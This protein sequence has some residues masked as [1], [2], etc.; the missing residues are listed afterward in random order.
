ME[1]DIGE[2]LRDGIDRVTE[3]NGLLLVGAFVLAGIASTVV[4]QTLTAHVVDVAAEFARQQGEPFDPSQAGPTPLAVSLPLWLTLILALGLALLVEALHIVAIRT[5]VSNER[6]TL[7]P[8]FLRRRIAWT[9]T[10]G[11]LGGIVVIVLLILPLAIASVISAV[12]RVVVGEAASL[13][14]LAVGLLIGGIITIFLFVSFFFVRQEIAVEDVNFVDAMAESWSLTEGNRVEVF[15]LGLV[16]G[17][18]EVVA[19]VPSLAQ[20]AADPA[21][22]VVV[23][24]VFSSVAGVFVIG[25]ATRAYAQMRVSDG[26]QT[27]PNG[28]HESEPETEDQYAGALGPEDLEPP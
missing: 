13:L 6:R 9:T 12:T 25:V 14:V 3:R 7:P 11:F 8:E 20:Q 23:A 4:T 2:A 17:F 5:F 26:D 27:P 10:N 1:L 19:G 16:L 21:A 15:V 24:T 28:N 22:V 18:V